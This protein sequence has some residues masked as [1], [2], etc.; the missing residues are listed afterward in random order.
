MTA[1]VEGS[2]ARPGRNLP[3]GKTRYPLYRRLGGHQGRSGRAENLVLAE[4]RSRTVQPVAQSLYRLSYP[5]HQQGK[6][7]Y[8]K[9]SNKRHYKLIAIWT[10]WPLINTNTPTFL[11]STNID[12]N[13]ILVYQ[14]SWRWLKMDHSSQKKYE[15]SYNK[16]KEKH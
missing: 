1:V 4:I 15:C 14:C 12:N 6:K 8:W 16:T 11:G 3:P 2:A 9:I 7:C 10:V 13:N 5:A